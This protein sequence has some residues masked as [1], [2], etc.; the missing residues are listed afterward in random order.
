MAKANVVIVHE[1]PQSVGK[2]VQYLQANGYEMFQAETLHAVFHIAQSS[3]PDVIVVPGNLHKL[4]GFQMCEEL[5]SEIDTCY[6]NIV[7]LVETVDAQVR[8]RAKEV[9]VNEVLLKTVDGPTLM[10]HIEALVNPA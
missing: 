5:R 7:M 4:D 9:G 6:A 3:K 8:K 2:I 10:K 1:S